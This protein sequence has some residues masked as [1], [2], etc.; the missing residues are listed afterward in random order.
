M[1]GPDVRESQPPEQRELLVGRRL[2]RQAVQRRDALAL[3]RLPVLRGGV[4]DMVRRT[5]SRGAAHRPGACTDPGS[6]WPAPR[7]R[8]SL[9][10]CASPADDRSL[11]VTE[12]G[13][14][15]A[16]A[17]AQAARAGDPPQR[18]GERLEVRHVQAAGVDAGRA[19]GDDRDAHR[20]ADDHRI[21]RGAAGGVVL[22]GV[23]QR[24]RAAARRPAA[25]GRGRTGPRRRRADRPGSR[26][27][28]R[29]RRRR[30]GGRAS[31]RRRTGARRC[32]GGAG[33]GERPGRPRSRRSAQRHADAIGWPVGEEGHADDPFVGDGAP[34]AAVVG[35]ATVVAH[36]EVVAGRN[37]DGLPE[38]AVF[39]AAAV[40]DVAVLLAHAVADD[41]AVEDRDAV[42]RAADDALDERLGGLLRRSGRRMAR[43][44]PAPWLGFPHTPLP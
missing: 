13:D 41:V 4:A 37:R 10:S 39:S 33:G 26:V 9:R 29:R 31:G 11:G 3:D 28:P 15:E 43:R 40:G 20:E 5:A 38:R 44:G 7:R 25:G 17:Q 32:C 24:P 34:E 18:I 21:Q 16:V 42:A 30:S 23:V 27:P 35:E 8:R 36:H 12:R 22:L 1:V 14:R 6:P 19:A 2:E